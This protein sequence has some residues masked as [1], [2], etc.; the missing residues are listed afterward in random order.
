[1]ASSKT[2]QKKIW[3]FFQS[4]SK[5]TFHPAIPRYNFLIKQ[6][7]EKTKFKNFKYRYRIR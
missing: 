6:S 5:D 4:N 7:K 3:D 1:M 2:D